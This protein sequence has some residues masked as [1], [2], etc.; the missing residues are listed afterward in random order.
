MEEYLKQLPKLAAQTKKENQQYFA[1]LKKRTP[2]NLDYIMQELH[3]A[4]FEKT[5]CLSCGNCC[6]T[7]SPIFTEK[8][9]ERISKYLKMKI[10]HF[11]NQYLRRDEDDFMVLKTAPCSFLDLQNN[12]CTIYD[13]RPKACSEYPHTNRRK[14]IQIANLTIE[15]TAICPATFKIVEDLKKRIPFDM[16]KK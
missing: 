15:N 16:S 13:V 14:F 12:E 3:D 8:D 9:I 5:D 7:T 10:L 11:T 6:K 4:A 1:L 2:K